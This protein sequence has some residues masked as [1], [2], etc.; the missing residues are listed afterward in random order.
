MIV[1][2]RVAELARLPW[3]FK[4]VALNPAKGFTPC[5]HGCARDSARGLMDQSEEFL[6]NTRDNH[7][8]IPKGL[9]RCGG[10]GL[11]ARGFGETLGRVGRRVHPGAQ[12]TLPIGT[13]DQQQKL[14]SRPYAHGVK[15]FA[16]LSATRLR[17]RV[18]S[19]ARQPWAD[20]LNAF[21][22]VRCT[23]SRATRQRFVY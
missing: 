4:R 23:L 8:P 16:G 3:V 10:V 5:A 13:S 15:P 1:Q 21:G 17:P 7:L 22:V 6:E 18:A 11:N 19:Q 14:P 20:L 12:G 9:N 2:P